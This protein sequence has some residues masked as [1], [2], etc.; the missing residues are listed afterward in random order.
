ML[1]GLNALVHPNFCCCL[2]ATAC[3][4][5]FSND[6][7]SYHFVAD[8]SA[9]TA[10]GAACSLVLSDG[11]AFGSVTCDTTDGAYN[12]A[13]AV[14][15]NDHAFLRDGLFTIICSAF[16]STQYAT[17]V[18]HSAMR[19]PTPPSDATPHS[20][21]LLYICKLMPCSRFCW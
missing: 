9:A 8:C 15:M 13:A 19:H 6:E 2:A 1:V 16:R 17:V 10:H 18:A 4:G 21:S 5:S 12:V 11:Y 20:P 7:L 3:A 14:G